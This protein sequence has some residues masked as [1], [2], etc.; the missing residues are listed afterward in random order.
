MYLTFALEMSLQRNGALRPQSLIMTDQQ[1]ITPVTC[2]FCQRPCQVSSLY[3]LDPQGQLKGWSCPHHAH[4]VQYIAI[5]DA[6]YYALMYTCWYDNQELSVEA[7]KLPQGERW[8]LH[9]GSEVI[10]QLDFLPKSLTPD[11]IDAR[12]QSLLLFS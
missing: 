7:Y 8:E 4:E 6:T 9:Q 5:P 2:H 11:S 3:Q 10:I 1:A 12:I